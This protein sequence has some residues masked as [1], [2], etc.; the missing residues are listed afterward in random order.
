VSTFEDGL[1]PTGEIHVATDGADDPGCGAQNDPCATIE[2]AAGGAEPGDAVIVHE[3]IHAGGGYIS[4]L[5]GTAQAPIWIGGAAGE[6]RPVIDG[7][8]QAFQLS[9]VRYLIVHDLEVRNST[10]NGINC[11]DGGDYDDPEA[12]RWVIFRDLY[13]HDVGAGG[14]QD[15]LKLSG[16]YDY[17]VLD[18][19]FAACGGGQSGSAIDHVGCHRGLLVGNDFHDLT[20]AG[21][22]VQCKGGSTDIEI[23][24]NSIV[25]GGARA[26]NM[27]GSTGFEFFRPPLSMNEPNA[28]AR[29]IRVIANVFRGSTT[30]IAFVGCVDC[31][32]AHNTI[33][34]PENWVARILQETSSTNE[35]EFLPASNSRFVGN[36][37][38]FELAGLS[39]FVNVGPD[40]D[41]DSFVFANNVWY[42]WDDPGQS[43][44]GN[45]LPVAEQDGVYGQDPGF[46]DAG[47][48][49]YHISPQSPAAGAGAGLDELGADFDG[50]CYGSPPSAGAFEAG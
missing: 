25:D 41:P 16:L 30:P 48:G 49:D 39:T 35:Y 15:C 5:A 24:G 10:Q 29:D 18:S 17:W 4:D 34:G 8:G 32:A 12:T 27:G 37:V 28:E 3:G 9:R 21:N 45:G 38:H 20:A 40:T 7:G 44:P 1:S 47:N 2:Y 23:R 42:A 46:A 50:V 43:D 22:A 26:I 19:E 6:Q 14:N 33:D 11:D 36:I 13:I 31:L